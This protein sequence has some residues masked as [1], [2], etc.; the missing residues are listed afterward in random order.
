MSQADTLLN[1]MADAGMNLYSV[2]PDTEQHI[3]I[4]DDRFIVVPEALKRIAVQYDH[5]IETITFDCPRYWD[6]HDLSK[7]AIY[8]NYMLPNNST[9]KYIADNVRATG[10]TMSFDWTIS[11]E[12]TQYKGSIA[13]LICINKTDEDG[14]EINHWN[15]ELNR[16]CYIAEGMEGEEVVLNEYPDI[17]SQLLLRMK[18]VEEIRPLVDAA[19]TTVLEAKAEVAAAREEVKQA[20]DLVLQRTSEVRDAY[21]NAI[22]NTETGE[23]VRVDDVSP[24]EHG[25]KTKVKSKNLAVRTSNKDIVTADGVTFIVNEDGTVTANGTATSTAYY[26]MQIGTGYTSQ[27]PIKKGQYTLGMAPVQGCR[28]SVGVRESESVERTLYYSTHNNTVTFDIT[29]DTAR[30]DIILCVDAGYTVTD[31]VFEPML[32]EGDTATEYTPYVDVSDAVI[33]RRGKNMFNPAYTDGIRDLNECTCWNSNITASKDTAKIFKPGVTYTISFEAE[34]LRDL[35]YS[36]L[37][38][39]D[40]GFILYSKSD[41]HESI[42]ICLHVGA[43]DDEWL[44]TGKKFRYQ[45]TITIPD[46]FDDEGADYRMFAYTQRAYNADGSAFL[47]TIRFNYIQIEVGEEATEPA[48]YTEA[49]YTADSDGNVYIPSMAPT[50]TLMSY[51]PGTMIECEYNRDSTAYL[52]SIMD[53]VAENNI[54]NMVDTVT[55]AFYYLSVANGKLILTKREV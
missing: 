21:A 11:R 24:I 54:T 52:K 12:I 6:D 19:V 53:A 20:E 34:G 15:S 22:K 7:M 5:N 47:N 8:I 26:L 46:N 45:N 41:A 50:M 10:D 1:A 27:T 9:G 23:V 35:E 31:A 44:T 42:P 32:V 48:E 36:R 25:V 16:D 3:V 55:G 4:G 51:V 33:V 29:S 39:S 18:S 43:N 28:V 2:E 40:I 13:F 49:E 37:F 17:V 14:N 30:F 38:A